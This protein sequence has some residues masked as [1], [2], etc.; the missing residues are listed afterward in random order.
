MSFFNFLLY[1]VIFC[2]FEIDL[3]DFLNDFESK[4]FKMVKQFYFENFS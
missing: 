4:F 2:L 1:F 3:S